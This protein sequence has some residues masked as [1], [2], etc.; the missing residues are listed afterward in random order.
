MVT[1]L[2]TFHKSG[3]VD[4][5][6]EKKLTEMIKDYN[7]TMGGIVTAEKNFTQRQN[8]IPYKLCDFY[9]LHCL[10]ISTRNFHQ[11]RIVVKVKFF[12]AFKILQ[13]RFRPEWLYLKQLE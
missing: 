13:L 12:S 11:V 10:W 6:H 2:I 7:R 5:E 1:L 8:V 3:D 4:S 9:A